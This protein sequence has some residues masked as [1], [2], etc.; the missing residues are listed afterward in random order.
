MCYTS[1]VSL[2]VVLGQRMNKILHPIYYASKAQKYYA[3]TKHE[4]LIMV[5]AFEKFHT[6]F[7]GT[8]IIVHIN[9]SALRY[10][11]AIKDVKPRLIRLL[12]LLEKIYLDL[13]D[14]RGIKIKWSNTC[15]NW[16]M[17]R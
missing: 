9:H 5:F 1:E 16:R 15:L 8:G 13:R 17:K 3:I 6:Y 10:L 7:H 2:G 14:R 11:T 12:L 4:L